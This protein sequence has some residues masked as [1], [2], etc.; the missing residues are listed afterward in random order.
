MELEIEAQ[1]KIDEVQQDFN[2]AFPYLRMEFLQLK[3][4]DNKAGKFVTAGTL[5][6]DVRKNIKHCIVKFPSNI[7][8]SEFENMF[9]HRVGLPV[10]VLR[11]SGNI[12]IETKM[13]RSW[14][15]DRQNAQ[16]KDLSVV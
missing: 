13:T 1:K 5:I 14:T 2:V 7:T 12:W 9:N 6:K 11:K 10:K 15:L 16:G 4:A 3:K 8:V